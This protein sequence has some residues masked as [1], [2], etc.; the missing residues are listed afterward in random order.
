MS[1]EKMFQVVH[2]S[3][4][5]RPVPRFEEFYS[6]IA[7]AS[8][9]LKGQSP[10]RKTHGPFKDRRC[11]FC[12]SVSPQVSFSKAAHVIPAA[13]GNRNHFSNEECDDCNSRYGESTEN[14]LSK[15]LEPE[16][17]FSRIRRRSGLPKLKAP[18]ADAY[19]EGRRE[20]ILRVCIQE[21][22]ETVQVRSA[23]EESIEIS[24]YKPPFRPISAIKSLLRSAW[25]LLSFEDRS[26]NYFILQLILG[27]L[28]IRPVEF[29]EYFVPGSGYSHASLKLWERSGEVASSDLVISLTLGN[30]ILSWCSPN[31]ESELYTPSLLP[32]LIGLAE[33]SL[34]P[35]GTLYRAETDDPFMRKGSIMYM[36]LRK[37]S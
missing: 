15:M 28:D 25:M 9:P 33:V 6:L 27:C 35:V 34:L 12:G 18:G 29:F 23:G 21:D 37:K 17:V 5:V 24:A 26:K 36:T 32:P 11:A 13:F 7:R 22:D 19:I 8:Y 14:E 16:R 2:P 4:T 3:W 20:N 30:T 10:R 31:L 1:H